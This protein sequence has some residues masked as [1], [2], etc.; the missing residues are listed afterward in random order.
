[1]NRL[2]VSDLFRLTPWRIPCI[3]LSIYMHLDWTDAHTGNV[4]P[5][6]LSHVALEGGG[7]RLLVRPEGSELFSVVR[8]KGLFK[9][10]LITEAAAPSRAEINEY[11]DKVRSL[12]V[13]ESQ[14]R[15]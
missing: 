3:D 9:R 13:I 5:L 7:M 1:M 4:H 12:G 14:L 8:I 15:V 6:K 10:R 2:E 11:L